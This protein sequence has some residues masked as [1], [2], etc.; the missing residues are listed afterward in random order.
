MQFHR[1]RYGWDGA[2][3]HDAVA[4]AHVIDGGLLTTEHVGVVVDTGP[5]LSR[6]RTHADRSG[7][8]DW[9]R[10]CHVAVG[11]DSD[12]FREL[13]ISRISSLG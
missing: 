10:N 12:R 5:E 6:G 3:V 7:L 13:L 8:A 4:M 9:E 1:R 2:P 11:I